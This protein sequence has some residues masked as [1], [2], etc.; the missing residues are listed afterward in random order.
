MRSLV[1][2]RWVQK[3]RSKPGVSTVVTRHQLNTPSVRSVQVGTPTLAVSLALRS[4]QLSAL[5]P[6]LCRNH[7]EG[8]STE[9]ACGDLSQDVTALTDAPAEM[10]P[11]FVTAQARKRALLRAPQHHTPPTSGRFR[12]KGFIPTAETASGGPP[13]P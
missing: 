1:D 11:S 5:R 6:D 12:D 10:E 2:G 4:N 8:R 7:A 13:S 9:W 3:T